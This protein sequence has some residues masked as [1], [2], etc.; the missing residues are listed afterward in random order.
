MYYVIQKIYDNQLK[1]YVSYKVPKFIA[2]PN[3]TNVIFEFSI[4]GKT[5]RK[6]APKKDIV[7][8]TDNIQHYK[9]VLNSLEN[10]K[11]KNLKNIDDAKA[12]LDNSISDFS[13]EIND[14]FEN[15]LQDEAFSLLKKS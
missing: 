7:L 10:I 11:S 4:D 14:E 13:K 15:I 3:N 2:A 5:K 12:N 9:K 6:W 1:H 8:L